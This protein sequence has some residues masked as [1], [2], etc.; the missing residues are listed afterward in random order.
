M[1]FSV[2]GKGNTTIICEGERGAISC[3]GTA[4]LNILYSNY[5]RTSCDICLHRAMGN[6][7][8]RASSSLSVIMDLCQ[9]ETACTITPSNSMFGDPCSYVYKYLE[10]RYDCVTTGKSL[11]YK[12][13]S[14][15]SFH[16]SSYNFESFKKE[17]M[18]KIAFS[19]SLLF[20]LILYSFC[21]R[22]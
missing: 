13:C 7:R 9:D 10:V 20:L 16:C 14:E 18:L 1:L 21:H 5:G 4:V 19:M 8:C 11:S 22:V 12:G 3:E 15:S 6:S 2:S 17:M